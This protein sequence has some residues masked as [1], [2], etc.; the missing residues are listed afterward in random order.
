MKKF[1]LGIIAILLVFAVGLTSG[2]PMLSAKAATLPS[3]VTLDTE[4]GVNLTSNGNFELPFTTRVQDLGLGW[5]L[6]TALDMETAPADEPKLT[7]WSFLDSIPDK[8]EGM[9]DVDTAI[10]LTFNGYRNPGDFLYY[11]GLK[12]TLDYYIGNGFNKFSFTMWVKTT[13]TVYFDIGLSNGGG[14]T[15]KIYD[16]G[17]RFQVT[18]SDGWVQIGMNASG[19][20][21]P[22]RR[23][24]STNTG[25]LNHTCSSVNQGV[26]NENLG[27]AEVLTGAT[28]SALKIGAYTSATGHSWTG[29][30]TSGT[31]TITGAQLWPIGYVD[32]TEL[33][34]LLLDSE[35]LNEAD[36]TSE[37]WAP[38]ASAI[39]EGMTVYLNANATKGE[40]DAAVL[41][42]QN[43]F[44]GLVEIVVE[45]PVTVVDKTALAAAI[46]TAESKNEADYTE[47]TFNALTSALEAAKAVNEDEEATQQQVNGALANL[48]A[49]INN[50]KAKSGGGGGS[51]GGCGTV[52]F[53]MRSGGG[54]LIMA[55]FSFMLVLL[56]R[57]RKTETV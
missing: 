28:W 56:V 2:L 57:K 46:A 17:R 35:L 9:G 33:N 8:V 18:S 5:G 49:A 27:E 50:L 4:P 10:E 19:E 23:H 7:S 44:A 6:P 30:P 37:S 31:V 21:Y 40:V 36:Y 3:A 16:L 43:A 24:S 15:N 22:F 32:R 39:E 26:N 1:K 52:G 45:P 42:I 53:D 14:S 38:Y 55:G 54:L 13:V 11:A 47:V 41:A 34:D 25:N 20:F 12:N 29:G 51:G 48:N